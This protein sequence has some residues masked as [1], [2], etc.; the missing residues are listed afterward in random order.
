MQ[1][2]IPLDEDHPEAW[3]ASARLVPYRPGLWLPGPL[4]AQAQENR[5]RFIPGEAPARPQA[6]HPAPPLSR[7]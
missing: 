3:P 2:F 7:N 6:E 5:G 4:P 1:V